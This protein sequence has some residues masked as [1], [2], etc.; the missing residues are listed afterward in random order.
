MHMGETVSRA[1]VSRHLK[2]LGHTYGTPSYYQALRELYIPVGDGTFYEK[3][4][5]ETFPAAR[6][7]LG[8]FAVGAND[9]TG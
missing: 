1:A 9:V 2:R 5:S 8:G 3:D 4:R 7:H 6:T